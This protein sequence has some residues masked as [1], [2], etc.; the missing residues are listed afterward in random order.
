MLHFEFLLGNSQLLIEFNGHIIQVEPYLNGWMVK[1]AR[2]LNSDSDKPK[3]SNAVAL[4][5]R[6]SQPLCFRCPERAIASGLAFVRQVSCA[7]SVSALLW[8]LH[9][10][11]RLTLQEYQKLS[12]SANRTL[13]ALFRW[14]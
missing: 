14:R 7:D 12:F 2:K 6:N 8:Q 1:V 13:S 5:D 9:Q 3:L 11:D 10:S 4:L